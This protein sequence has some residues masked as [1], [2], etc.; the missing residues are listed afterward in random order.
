MQVPRPYLDSSI[1]LYPPD[2]MVLYQ[3]SLLF[4][5]TLYNC[6]RRLPLGQRS[7][8]DQRQLKPFVDVCDQYEIDPARGPGYWLQ[9]PPFGQIRSP[10]G[11]ATDGSAVYVQVRRRACA[12]LQNDGLLAAEETNPAPG[13]A[14]NVM[15]F[16]PPPLF[17]GRLHFGREGAWQRR[18]PA[19]WW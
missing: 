4:T 12:C 13:H 5:D 18:V 10:L 2:G 16:C 6:I 17:A 14:E 11:I 15:H 8:T 3:D 19:A 1:P 7:V 9:R